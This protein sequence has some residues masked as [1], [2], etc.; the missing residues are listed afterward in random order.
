MALIV[1]PPFLFGHNEAFN[2]DTNAIYALVAIILGSVFIQPNVY[3]V[4]R[5]LKGTLLRCKRNC[6]VNCI[7]N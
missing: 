4:L 7:L 2:Y 5:L 1:Q 6:T 3:V